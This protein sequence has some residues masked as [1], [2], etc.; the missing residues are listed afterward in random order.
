[1]LVLPADRVSLLAGKELNGTPNLVVE[2]LSESTHRYDQ[3]EEQ[4]ISCNMEVER[5]P[6]AKKQLIDGP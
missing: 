3:Q 5:G 6:E 4:H 1:M 2:A